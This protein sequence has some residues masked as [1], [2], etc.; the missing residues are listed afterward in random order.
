MKMSRLY[1]HIWLLLVV[2]LSVNN[3]H[4]QNN[5]YS[6]SG[7]ILDI[8][9]VAPLFYVNVGLLNEID[10]A[11]INVTTTDKNGVFKFLNVKEGNYI[12][13]TSYIGYG[14]I[15]LSELL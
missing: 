7:K 1:F 13:K 4:A 12:I 15:K 6:I 5:T 9:S 14:Y 11:I 10:S 3:I 8:N 2:I